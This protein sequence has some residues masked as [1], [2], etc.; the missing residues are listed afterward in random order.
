[1]FVN[2]V[3]RN[4]LRMVEMTG[5]SKLSSVSLVIACVVPIILSVGCEKERKPMSIPLINDLSRARIRTD[6][7]SMI[8]QRSYV[9]GGEKRRVL[10]M[11]PPSAVEY[12]VLVPAA[13]RLGFGFALAPGVW[14]KSGDGVLFRVDL[15][16]GTGE[17]VELFSQYIN[18]KAV[19]PDRKW[20]DAEI[21]LSLYEGQRVTLIFS[22]EPGPQNNNAF[23]EAAWSEPKVTG[24]VW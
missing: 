6:N 23:D 18:P 7:P 17:R 9:I 8:A 13:A 19:E 16:E 15:D 3:G 5:R 2:D 24:V 20:H 12:D 1:M 10:F 22:T 14:N 11:H 4:T 21:D